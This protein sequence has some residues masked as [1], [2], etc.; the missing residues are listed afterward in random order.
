MFK[1]AIILSIISIAMLNASTWGEQNKQKSWT[2]K[3]KSTNWDKKYQRSKSSSN[4]SKNSI[5]MGNFTEADAKKLKDMSGTDIQDKV[6]KQQK[7]NGGSARERLAEMQA[8]EKKAESKEERK[9]CWL[10]KKQIQFNS[11]MD[12]SKNHYSRDHKK[13]MEFLKNKYKQQLNSDPSRYK[14][15]NYVPDWDNIKYPG[16]KQ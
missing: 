6:R 4:Y 8:C 11:E 10:T 16:V 14:Q 9:K 1:A 12:M 2:E 5:S 7:E 15:N 3:H 13:E